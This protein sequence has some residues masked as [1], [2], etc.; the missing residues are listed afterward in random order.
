MYNAMKEYNFKEFKVYYDLGSDRYTTVDWRKELGNYLLARLG[1]VEGVDLAMR[2]Y[3]SDDPVSLSDEEVQ[4]LKALFAR[5]LEEG[6]LVAAYYYSF[7]RHTEQP[8]TEV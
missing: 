5:K 3:K 1:G 8:D 2:V 4:T 6:G 7:L